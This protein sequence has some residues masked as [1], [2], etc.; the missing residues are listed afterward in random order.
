MRSNSSLTAALPHPRERERVRAPRRVLDLAVQ[1]PPQGLL[2]RAAEG[3]PL[4]HPGREQVVASDLEPDA[5][6]ARR[7][8]AARAPRARPAPARAPAPRAARS[9]SSAWSADGG[10]RA[11]RSA[12]TSRGATRAAARDRVA[13]ARPSGSS[14]THRSSSCGSA[15]TSAASAASHPVGADRRPRRAPPTPPAP[16]SA[17]S[18]GCSAVVDARA[19]AAAPPPRRPRARASRSSSS[20]R[21]RAPE[22]VASASRDRLA[23]EPLGL[24]V[25][26]EAEARL[27]AHAA[28]EPGRVVDEAPV[29]EHAHEA[30]RRGRRSP[31][32]GSCSWPRS[33][34]FSP[35][36]IALIAKSRRRE[37]LLQRRRLHVAAARP[38]RRRSRVGWSARSNPGRSPRTVAVPKRSCSR[39][40]RRA[41]RRA[42]GHRAGVA[43]DGHVEVDGRLAEQE[44]AHRAA[45]EVGR[46]QAVERRQQPL[47][48]GQA[49][50]ALAQRHPR[51][52]SQPHRDSRRAH[53]LLG[54]AHR[55][56]PVV[57][58][59][60]AQHGVGAALRRSRRPG[61]RACPRRP[62]RS[63]A[64]PPRPPPR[65]SARARSRPRCR[66]GPCSSAGSPPPRA[67]L[68]RGPTR[69][70][71]GPPAVRPP[72]TY[73]S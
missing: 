26:P 50:D 32:C 53:R 67:R 5:R 48:A 43:L 2:E 16:G 10:A 37:V 22:T 61:G 40:R 51:A 68:P 72:S 55:V 31:P 66:R 29:V 39:A 6:S 27:V 47:H 65:A 59:R 23:R 28:Q 60:G 19:R 9:P 17:S 21:T 25:H 11:A 62:R 34:P 63:P 46:R 15:D 45:H 13:V 14:A 35:T 33:S 56:L 41:A 71:R 8:S 1:L 38:A 4:R 12:V 52:R 20:S 42:P 54:L 24:G 18:A 3:G 44:V 57:E 64:R 30:A 7:P 70:R 36:A 73:T 58:D 69:P 49:P